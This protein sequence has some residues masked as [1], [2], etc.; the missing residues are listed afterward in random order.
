MA[1]Q[2][3]QTFPAKLPGRKLQ[4]TGGGSYQRVTRARTCAPT[5]DTRPP[6]SKYPKGSYLS[7]PR[8]IEDTRSSVEQRPLTKAA[9][10]LLADYYR[11]TAFN[12]AVR[13]G[14]PV[15]WA[16]EHILRVKKVRAHEILN[17]LVA[18]GGAWEW[19]IHSALQ[20]MSEG[21]IG[22]GR[23]TLKSRLATAFFTT[24]AGGERGLTYIRAQLGCKEKISLDQV[25]RH[26]HEDYAE[27]IDY[28]AYS[29]LLWRLDE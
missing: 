17:E 15:E 3:H 16:G 28:L 2:K 29:Q 27:V 18:H 21:K 4:K 8:I 6:S 19:F 25:R 26:Q 24:L 11:R 1:Q 22:R 10:K 12:D 13:E 7:A 5:T 14:A 23:E 9:E 20:M